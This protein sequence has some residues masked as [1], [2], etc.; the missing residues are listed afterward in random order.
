MSQPMPDLA[1]LNRKIALEPPLDISRPLRAHLVGICGSGMKALAEFLSD[2]LWQLTGSDQDE[3][4]V[5]RSLALQSRGIRITPGHHPGALPADTQLLIFSPAIPPRNAERIR[6]AELGIPQISYND[7]LGLLMRD[8]RGLVVTGTHGKSTT[9]AILAHLLMAADRSPSVIIGA[10]TRNESHWSGKLG[11]GDDFVVEGCEYRR[12]FLKLSATH[13]IILGIEPDHFDYFTS[14]DDTIAAFREFAQSIP[15]AGSLCI[16]ANDP[17]VAAA[18]GNVACQIQTFSIS[19]NADWTAKNIRRSAGWTVFDVHHL[20]RPLFTT[21]LPLPGLH[22]VE[23][24]LAAI[25]LA[26]RVGVPPELIATS[27]P[28][29]PGIR[30]RFEIVRTKNGITWIDDYAHHPTAI[31]ATLRSARDEYPLSRIR[32]LFQPHQTNRTEHLLE[33]FADSF[34]DADDVLIAPVFGA[35][36]HPTSQTTISQRLAERISLHGPPAAFVDTLDLLR[37]RGEDGLR[38]GD[39]V[40]MIGAGDINRIQ[41]GST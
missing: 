17:A 1:D 7:L 30:R 9:T 34:A 3:V 29:F 38:N 22:N 20:G 40:L 39:V 31:R 41:H 37:A 13:G 18:T 23:N 36:E 33:Q 24:S 28:T 35:R 15:P 6:A 2:S 8:R 12:N 21:R 19:S 5:S 14:F 4:A 32:V 25:S 16:R 11:S 27:L 26:F 10:E